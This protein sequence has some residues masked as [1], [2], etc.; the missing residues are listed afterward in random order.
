MFTDLF[1]ATQDY[2]RKLDEVEAAY[3]RDEMTLEEVN[4]EVQRLMI[5][6]GNHRRLAI[7][8]FWASL[9]YFIQQQ[10]EVLA[11]TAV[12]GVLAYIWLA[13]AV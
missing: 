1:S 6:L 13:N 4:A 2:W 3:K 10:R 7:K 9:Q 12:I 5:D 8:D 11:G